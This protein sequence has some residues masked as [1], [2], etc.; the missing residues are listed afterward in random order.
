MFVWFGNVLV[1]GHA[2]HIALVVADPPLWMLQKVGMELVERPI[3]D[4]VVVKDRGDVWVLC[5]H[6]LKRI[7][8]LVLRKPCICRIKHAFALF[9][10][11]ERELN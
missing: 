11:D 9:D 5:F 6:P 3:E 10:G 4:T 2:A 8:D 1:A 7:H